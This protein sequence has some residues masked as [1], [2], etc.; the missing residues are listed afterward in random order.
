MTFSSPPTEAEFLRTGLFAEPLVPVA[1]TTAA[2]NQDLAAALLTYR[3]AVKESGE[4]DAVEAIAAFL[5]TH[6][7]SPWKPALQLNLGIIYRKTGHFSKALDIWQAGWSDAQ[8]LSDAHGR[9]LANAM[10]ARLSQLEAYLGRKELLEPL[11]GSIDGRSVGG[12]AAQLITDSHTGLYD[13]VYH[14]DESFRCGPLAL[15]RIL[16]YGNAQ[17]SARAM[18]VLD[19]AHS[20]RNGLSLKTVQQ[21]A[22]EAGMHYQVAFRALGAPIILPAVAHWKVGHYAALVDR[23]SNGRFIVEDTTFGEDMRLLM[24]RR[25][26]IF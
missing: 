15:T 2:E 6:P 3:D 17:P 18:Q 25:A 11:L 5:D 1:A 24:K 23:G 16:K 10:V 19:N 21:I 26:G 9:A 22:T 20:T 4:S 7:A 14:P 12:T 8:A 13:M